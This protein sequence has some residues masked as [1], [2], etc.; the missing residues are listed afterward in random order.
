MF[1]P[2]LVVLVKEITGDANTKTSEKDR[3]FRVR[4]VL[5]YNLTDRKTLQFHTLNYF[6]KQKVMFLTRNDS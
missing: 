3:Y 2:F 1:L 6:I 4:G 5:W